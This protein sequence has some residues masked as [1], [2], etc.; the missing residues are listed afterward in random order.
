MI[1]KANQDNGNLKNA[2]DSGF[3]KSYSA[4]FGR[5]ILPNGRFNIVRVGKKTHSWFHELINLTWPVFLLLIFVFYCL[6]NF[7]FAGAYFLLGPE[8]INGISPG[9]DWSLFLQCYFFSVQSFTTVGYGGLHPIGFGA[10]FL[11]GVEALSG[12]LTFAIITGL[13]Y[14]KF[15]IPG[16]HII[17]SKKLLFAP[18]KEIKSVQVRIANENQYDLL[19]IEANLIVAYIPEQSN[20]RVVRTLPLEIKKIAMFPLSWTLVHPLNE[21]S[22]LK[23]FSKEEFMNLNF[24]FILLVS[25]YDEGTGRTIKS[26]HSFDH[27][28]FVFNAKFKPMFDLKD[29]RTFLHLDKINEIEILD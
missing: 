10:S 17:A 16:K 26:I 13:V 20:I 5:M 2:E 8:Q 23:N 25:A 11:A 19:D 1:N 28:S 6:I 24:E 12:L 3:G 21:E 4:Q 27:N 29:G 9:P 18:Y 15:S 14:S 22:E 7:F